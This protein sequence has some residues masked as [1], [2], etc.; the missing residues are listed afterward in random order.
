MSITTAARVNQNCRLRQSAEAPVC[1]ILDHVEEEF[2][3]PLEACGSCAQGHWVGARGVGAE[4]PPPPVVA[5]G[6]MW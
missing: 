4:A 2:G 6:G 1:S 3:Q 5:C